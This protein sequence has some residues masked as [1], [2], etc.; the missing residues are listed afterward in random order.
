MKPAPNGTRRRIL[1]V[2]DDEDTCDLFKLWLD[3]DGYVTSIAL[4]ADQ[5]ISMATELRPHAVIIDIGLPRQSGI[6]LLG[7]LLQRPILEGCRYLAITAYPLEMA[8]HCAAAGFH[9]F[10]QKPIQYAVLVEAMRQL[11]SQ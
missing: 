6:E 2:D 3:R 1:V 4:D 11:C 8:E 5:A 7:L 10:Y 9:A